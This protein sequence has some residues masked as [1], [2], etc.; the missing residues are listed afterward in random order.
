MI[1][2]LHVVS[3]LLLSCAG[4]LLGLC[5]QQWRQS[6]PSQDT[7]GKR[8][9]I[10]R[11]QELRGAEEKGIP[12]VSPLVT[13]AEAFALLLTPPQPPASR[14]VPAPKAYTPPVPPVVRPPSV[15]PQFAL[16]STSYC[17]SRPARSLALISEPGQESRW[18][19][20]GAQ[21]GHL[22][23][24]RIDKG[25]MIYRDG[26]Q[27]REMRIT[28]P[29]PLPIARLKSNVPGPIPNTRANGGFSPASPPRADRMGVSDV[30]PIAQEFE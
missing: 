23:V 24:E 26:D 29:E 7:G 8:S 27:V 3:V 19:G 13:E 17:R 11:F 28:V 1:K 21:V 2:V 14:E 12:H 16:L 18:I 6:L 20:T 10:A 9:A 30:Q 22:V 25:V 5:V 4:V 15:T